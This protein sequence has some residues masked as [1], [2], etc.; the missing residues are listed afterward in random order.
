MAARAAKTAATGKKPGGRVPAPP[1]ETPLPSDQINLTDEESRIMPVAGGGFEQCYNAQ[2]AVAA[3]SLLVVAADVVQAPNDKQQLAPMLD[4]IAA[5]P[6]ELGEPD[7]L[8]ADNGYF[9]EANVEACESAGI[10]PVIALG[11]EAHHPSLVERFA[12]APPAPED[13]KAAR[14]HGASATDTAGQ[15]TLRPAQAHPGAG[16]RHHQ[17]GA[18]ISP[19]LAAR[20]RGRSRR[21]ETCDHGVEFEADVRTWFRHLSAN[22]GSVAPR[23][24]C[25][26][27]AGAPGPRGRSLLASVCTNSCSARLNGGPSPTGC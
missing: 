27:P 9:S 18:G 5:L 8:L 3:G 6:D 10:D 11:R 24:A 14:G 12:A 21:V 26:G 17:V 13:P 19:V 20:A 15:D 2:A 23:G 4:K 7:M 22:V 25:S 1:V 16:V